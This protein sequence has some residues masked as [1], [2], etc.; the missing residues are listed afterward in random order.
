MSS[1]FSAAS[2]VLASFRARSESRGDHRVE[3]RVVPFDLL[4][5]GLQG[6]S[7][8][9]LPPSQPARQPPLRTASRDHHP[10]S[11]DGP[12]ICCSARRAHAPL[13]A[14]FPGQ[15][16]RRVVKLI[17]RFRSRASFILNL[18]RGWALLR[19]RGQDFGLR[20]SV[21][22]QSPSWTNGSGAGANSAPHAMDRPGGTR[23]DSDWSAHIG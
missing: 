12:R 20:G 19:R 15:G 10:P 13:L 2:A 14:R 11:S 4:E 16:L 18:R 9:Q 17:G 1:R 3:R 7:G 21:S 5:V 6:L 23:I 8:G 22:G